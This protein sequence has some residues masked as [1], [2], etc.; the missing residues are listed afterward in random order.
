VLDAEVLLDNRQVIVHYL[1]S[2][3]CD[4]R[5]L[6][7]ALSDRHSVLVTMH[8]LSL[9]EAREV[10][11]EPAGCGSGGCGSSCGSCQTGKCSTCSLHNLSELIRPPRPPR[12]GR[13]DSVA[14]I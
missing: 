6:M 5:P 11:E 7:D 12:A 8:D 10:E 13:Y 3:E 14:A 1:G 4:P 2:K 9:P